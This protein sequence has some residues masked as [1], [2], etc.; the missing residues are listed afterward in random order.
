[1]NEITLKAFGLVAGAL[2][3]LGA[4]RTHPDAN[5][6]ILD[7]TPIPVTIE[8]D[9]VPATVEQTTVTETSLPTTIANCDDA[10][11]L[12]RQVGWPEEELDT[13]AVV[14]LRE[15][16]CTPTAHNLDDPMGGSYGLTQI[17]GFWCLPNS[18]WPMG[19]LQVQ[20]I[21]VSECGELFIPEANLRAALAI[22]HN[23]GW[24]PWTATAP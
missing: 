17:N 5:G 15:S 19:W 21:G 12:A 2:L 11:N 20:D 9:P 23:S 14:M 6:A 16:N 1:M 7:P 18:A 4:L 8:A 3:A 10:V 13:L 22:W 24:G